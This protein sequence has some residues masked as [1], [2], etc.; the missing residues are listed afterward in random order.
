MELETNL[1]NPDHRVA[2]FITRINEAIDTVFESA[3]GIETDAMDRTKSTAQDIK[4]INAEYFD[5]IDLNLIDF[6]KV[7]SLITTLG[8]AL[9]LIAK[10]DLASAKK[11]LLVAVSFIA[12]NVDGP[13][14][15]WLDQE[16]DAGALLDAGADKLK[17]IMVGTAAWQQD[18]APKSLLAAVGTIEASH[19]GLTIAAKLQHKQASFRPPKTAKYAMFARNTAV[20][21]FMISK[22][23]TDTDPESK[24]GK[25]LHVAAIGF[26]AISACLEIPV[27]TTYANRTR[28][29][30]VAEATV[31]TPSDGDNS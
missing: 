26:T 2:N 31:M 4:A 3:A 29:N 20:G 21:M 28:K 5:T 24:L 10:N 12:D 27:L 1:D 17:V 14:A 11:L 16:S 7:P 6:V 30:G 13:L 25:R 9:A 23:M 15:R 18:A 19:V 8:T 22:S